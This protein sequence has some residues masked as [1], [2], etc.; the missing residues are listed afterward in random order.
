MSE[1][2]QSYFNIQSINHSYN[3]VYSHRLFTHFYIVMDLLIYEE[4]VSREWGFDKERGGGVCY[5]LD[6]FRR[7]LLICFLKDLRSSASL[8]SGGRLFQVLAPW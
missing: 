6:G 1:L 7:Y 5:W 2:V 4:G 8:R 3:L